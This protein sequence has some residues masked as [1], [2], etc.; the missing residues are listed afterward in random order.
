MVWSGVPF[1]RAIVA[2][3]W[4]AACRRKGIF[5][6]ILWEIFSVHTLSC[7]KLFIPRIRS[8]R[9]IN[10]RE[11]IVTRS[12]SIPFQQT[13]YLPVN[14][15]FKQ[16]AGLL[17]SI[18]DYPGKISLFLESNIYEWHSASI[19]TEHKNISG[20]A[21]RCSDWKWQVGKRLHLIHR[22]TLFDGLFRP[23]SDI[24][25]GEGNTRF[26]SRH[27]RLYTAFILCK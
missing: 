22:K 13:L 6:S 7:Y 9:F 3:Q 19:D 17:P 25:K 5:I 4:R 14:T 23:D 20:Q 21:F 12:I 8:F 27:P 18:A 15:Y 10:Q 26:N 2:Q 1:S 11:K 24:A 16:L